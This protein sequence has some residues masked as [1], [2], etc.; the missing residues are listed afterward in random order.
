MSEKI[1]K[2]H[3][4]KVSKVHLVGRDLY[5]IDIDA[6]NFTANAGQFVSILCDNCTLRRPF[7]VKGYTYSKSGCRHRTSGWY[8]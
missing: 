6:D 3:T 1:K 8:A 7:S 4:G 5:E 2:I